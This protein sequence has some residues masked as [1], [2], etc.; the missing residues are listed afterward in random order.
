LAAEG[1]RAASGP[2]RRPAVAP[3][4]RAFAANVRSPPFPG[5][6]AG[7]A[8]IRGH[9][10]AGGSSPD[11]A[12]RGR[13]RE[14][15]GNVVRVRTTRAVCP[16][17]GE[18][19]LFGRRARRLSLP[20][21][22]SSPPTGSALLHWLKRRILMCARRVIGGMSVQTAP[23]CG[24]NHYGSISYCSVFSCTNDVRYRGCC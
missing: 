15:S 23:R 14:G 5:E 22:P 18:R 10:I 1:P 4:E 24:G 6:F 11:R 3:R 12:R 2:V 21:R 7:D 20:R 19:A 9:R 13:R 16:D 17:D 8:T